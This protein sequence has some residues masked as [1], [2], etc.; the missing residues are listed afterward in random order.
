MLPPWTDLSLRILLLWVINVIMFFS[1]NMISS[2]TVFSVYMG[3][4]VI[5]CIGNSDPPPC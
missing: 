1:A 4:L 3:G 5:E 2:S